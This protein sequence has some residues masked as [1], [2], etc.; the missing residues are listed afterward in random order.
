M[1]N[2]ECFFNLW[3]KFKTY[4][5]YVAGFWKFYHL[6]TIN[7]IITSISSNLK[8]NF[9]KQPEKSVRD[10]LNYQNYCRNTLDLIM[11]LSDKV[12]NL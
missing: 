4:N 2:A 5:V 7:K 9:G 1:Y 12:A 3:A 6:H 11:G 8:Y 10:T